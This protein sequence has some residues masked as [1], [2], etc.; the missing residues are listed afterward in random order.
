MT[1]NDA[2]NEIDEDIEAYRHANDNNEDDEN[3]V[4]R[5]TNNQDTAGLTDTQKSL[6]AT[7][8]I[9]VGSKTWD[10]NNTA[11]LAKE[12]NKDNVIIEI[13]SFS[14]KED[15]EILR[16]EDIKRLFVSMEFLNYDPYDL[17]SNISQP[18]PAPNQPAFF[19][20]RKSLSLI[21]FMIAIRSEIFSCLYIIIVI[22]FAVDARSNYDKRQLL[23]AM[24]VDKNKSTYV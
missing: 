5:V 19:H 23:A 12:G 24:L 15:T 8:D 16:R 6:G 3:S 4:T 21:T 13:T 2:E 14:L 17:E 1:E 20:F 22:V 7:D 11:K 10:P 9:V 18:K